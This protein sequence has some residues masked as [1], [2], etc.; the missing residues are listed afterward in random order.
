MVVIQKFGRRV[1]DASIYI[2][3]YASLLNMSIRIGDSDCQCR[4]FVINLNCPDA[5]EKRGIPR[6]MDEG[7]LGRPRDV[8]D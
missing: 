7:E 8:H 4:S 5:T 6:I 1:G 3:I 2:Y